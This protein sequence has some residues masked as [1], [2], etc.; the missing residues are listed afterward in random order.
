MICSVRM[1]AFSTLLGG[2]LLGSA[3]AAAF[4][5]SVACGDAAPPRPPLRVPEPPRVVAGGAPE[6]P[7]VYQGKPR[8]SRVDSDAW[9]ALLA[10]LSRPDAALERLAVPDCL[11][12]REGGVCTTGLSLT[13]VA[14]LNT[15]RLEARGLAFPGELYQG[16][17]DE[18]ARVEIELPDKSACTTVIAHGGGSIREVDV[19]LATRTRD[20]LTLLAPDQRKGPS[21]LVGGRDA[22]ILP[23]PSSD[24]RA[25]VRVRSGKG[26]VVLGVFQRTEGAR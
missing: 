7:G 1:R 3:S 5:A 2:P 6:P 17:L 26:L 13:A 8:I 24:P 9:P 15:A 18:G 22:C 25:L 10:D 16:E 11:P 23:P 12:E 20:G 21:A 14:L 4:A 19:F